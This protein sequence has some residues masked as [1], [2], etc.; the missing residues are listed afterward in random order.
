MEEQP[1]KSQRQK[2]NEKH[3]IIVVQC[4]ITKSI[5]KIEEKDVF[6]VFTVVV[7]RLFRCGVSFLKI[8]PFLQHLMYFR[9]LLCL[10]IRKRM[11]KTDKVLL[12]FCVRIAS[13]EMMFS[14]TFLQY[15]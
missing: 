10:V 1:G 15:T 12:V 7:N 4:V 5:K 11:G 13:V 2:L 6:T 14:S 8:P 3:E 9:L